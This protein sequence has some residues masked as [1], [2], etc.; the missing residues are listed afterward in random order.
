MDFGGCPGSASFVDLMPTYRVMYAKSRTAIANFAPDNSLAV[1]GIYFTSL[2]KEQPMLLPLSFGSYEDLLKALLSN[3]FLGSGRG[4]HPYQTHLNLVEDPQPSPWRAA[5]PSPAQQAVAL[6]ISAATAKETASV[7][8]SAVA[9]QVAAS[10]EAS[11]AEVIDDYCGTPP[12]KVPWPFPGP[13][14]WVWEIASQ[15]T[16]AANTLQEG[17]LR[18]NLLQISGRV[19]EKGLGQSKTG[20]AAGAR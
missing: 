4:G 14:P 8:N 7:A 13:P 3:P 17:S 11:I 9:K 19:L 6:L 12:R 10:A 18:T 20:A 2:G 16:V 1:L 15:L 5:Y